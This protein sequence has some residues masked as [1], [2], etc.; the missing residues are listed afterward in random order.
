MSL[1]QYQQEKKAKIFLLM[2]EKDK[3]RIILESNRL[4]LSMTSYCLSTIL[5]SLNEKEMEEISN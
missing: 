4:G 1:N 5:K 3:T 2:R